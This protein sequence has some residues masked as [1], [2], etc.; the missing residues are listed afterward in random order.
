MS[1]PITRTMVPETKHVGNEAATPR[2]GSG[3]V[4]TNT[5]IGTAMH[6]PNDANI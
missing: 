1:K 3:S 2:Y 5:D 4:K 6:A